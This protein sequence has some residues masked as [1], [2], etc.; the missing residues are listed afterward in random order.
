MKKIIFIACI[1]GLV[2][3]SC[4]KSYTCECTDGTPDN[5]V[6]TEGINVKNK[7]EAQEYCRSLGDEC[8][9]R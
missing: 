7:T 9:I 5:V 6:Y 2:H 1:I 3:S 8:D 4:S